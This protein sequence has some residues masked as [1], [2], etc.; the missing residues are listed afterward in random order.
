MHTIYEA[1][2]ASPAATEH[3]WGL[4]GLVRMGDATAL[5]TL[6]ANVSQLSAT[7]M[8]ATRILDGKQVEVRYGDPTA[9]SILQISLASISLP[10]PAA[11][12]A[13]GAIL[14]APGA[15]LAVQLGAARA[16]ADDHSPAAIR[17]LA[18]LLS[19]LNPDLQSWAVGGIASF[20][21]AAPPLDLSKGPA[22]L[23]INRQGPFRTKA[24]FL[25]WTIGASNVRK[26]LQYYVQFWKRWWAQNSG[27]IP[28]HQVAG[29]RPRRPC[30]APSARAE[31]RSAP[32]WRLRRNPRGRG[33]SVA[34]E[35]PA[36]RP[37]LH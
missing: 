14:D 29:A 22:G 5:A 9:G 19:S 7:P 26:H 15:P 20:A 34:S 3:L 17:F 25:H 24:T 31:Y 13:L 8:P 30:P 36:A 6:A 33:G 23:H 32:P 12:T 27:L 21:N 18:P 2:A 37:P 11:V 10:S 28:A 4:L 16:L 35:S 1:L